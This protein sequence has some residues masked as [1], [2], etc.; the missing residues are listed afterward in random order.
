M[1][2]GVTDRAVKP[3]TSKAGKRAQL[4]AARKTNIKSVVVIRE[5][6]ST[7]LRPSQSL[8]EPPARAPTTPA[9]SNIEREAPANQKL[10][11]SSVRKMGR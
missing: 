5:M 8:T 7:C 6:S 11:P 10:A 1:S 9:A 4:S 2:T 3:S